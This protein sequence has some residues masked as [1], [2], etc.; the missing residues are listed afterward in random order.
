MEPEV[1][2]YH[3]HIYFDANIRASAHALRETLRR[4]FPGRVRVHDLIDEPIGPHPLPRFEVDV[5]AP[6]IETVKAWLT[7]HRGPHSILILPLTG[8]DL[9]DHRD[10]PHWLG[11]PLKLDLEFL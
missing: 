9:A 7:T 11:P 4:A 8:N 2:V 6:E 3:V 5:P 10:F 1:S